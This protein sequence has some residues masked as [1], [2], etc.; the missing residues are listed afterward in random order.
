MIQFENRP[1]GGSIFKI[2]LPLNTESVQLE[3]ND[4]NKL[5]KGNSTILI[6]DDEDIVRRGAQMMLTRQGYRT[7]LASDGEE[8]IQRLVESTDGIDAVLLDLSM[9]GMPGAEVLQR[10]KQQWPNLPVVLCSGY[11]SDETPRIDGPDAIIPK[12]Y[13][14]R[15][16]ITTI[17]DVTSSPGPSVKSTH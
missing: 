16:L 5:P 2:L 3:K 12:P 14:F 1:G 15:K 9:P 7:V 10:V 8:A 4:R 11:L 17:A 13:S 6:V